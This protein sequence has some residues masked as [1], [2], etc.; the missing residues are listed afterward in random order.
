MT[1]AEAQL[2]QQSAAADDA[3]RDA[4]MRAIEA[5]EKAEAAEQRAAEAQQRA[6]EEREARERQSSNPVYW[7]NWGYGVSS[8]P[9]S[10]WTSYQPVSRAKVKLGVK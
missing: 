10:G 1:P 5:E 6:E 2:A 8:W 4:E 9:A 7:G 3:R